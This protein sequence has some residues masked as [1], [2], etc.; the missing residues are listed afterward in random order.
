MHG[1]KLVN[2][3]Y[4]RPAGVEAIHERRR[5]PVKIGPQSR[6][7]SEAT[8]WKKASPTIWSS[9]YVDNQTLRCNYDRRYTRFMAIAISRRSTF[10]T[11]QALRSVGMSAAAFLFS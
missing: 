5:P 10:A 1:L 2:E 9:R 4:A 7:R 6:Y 8:P 3:R 11:V